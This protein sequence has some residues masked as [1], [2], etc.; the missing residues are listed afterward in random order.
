MKPETRFGLMIAGGIFLL[1]CIYFFV[2]PVY[3]VW[4]EGKA[5]EARLAHAKFAKEV[6]VAESKAAYEAGSYLAGLDTLRAHGTARANEIIGKSISP[7]YLQWLWVQ[8]LEKQEKSVI[9]VPSVNGIPT[10][11]VQE[12]TRLQQPT[13]INQQP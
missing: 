9:Y 3:T 10:M 12:A 1:L 6:A 4:S 13:I 11:P 8:N 5:G 7:Q 2:G